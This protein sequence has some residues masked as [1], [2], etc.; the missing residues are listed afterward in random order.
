MY[1]E[2]MNGVKIYEP[3]EVRSNDEFNKNDLVAAVRYDD[4]LRYIDFEP[5]TIEEF[6]RKDLLF[7]FDISKINEMN[8]LP[9][10]EKI[11]FSLDIMKN[12]TLYLTLGRTLRLD[13]LYCEKV[14][15]NVFAK[16]PISWEDYK[17]I[18][19]EDFE[20]EDHE[21]LLKKYFGC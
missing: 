1:K 4:D 12:P 14:K 19:E 2:I 15:R 20:S 5:M 17:K 10:L 7:A 18:P 9:I 6:G 21:Y 3:Y 11:E 8:N 16:R 13:Y